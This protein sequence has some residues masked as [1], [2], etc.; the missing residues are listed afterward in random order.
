MLKLCFSL[1]YR[2]WILL[3]VL[4]LLIPWMSL[5]RSVLIHRTCLVLLMSCN[6]TM[7]DLN[8]WD[9]LQSME[10]LEMKVI[11]ASIVLSRPM[12]SMVEMKAPLLMLEALLINKRSRKRFQW[13]K[14]R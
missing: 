7:A 1:L 4:L 6:L 12:I 11:L 2:N 14:Q 9:L 8:I 13:K 3:L 5:M 10:L